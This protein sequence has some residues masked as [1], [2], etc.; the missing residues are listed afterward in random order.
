L[1]F[2]RA[3]LIVAIAL[4]VVIL[5]NVGIYYGYAR[6]NSRN[7]FKDMINVVKLARNPWEE[8]DNN[9]KELSQRVEDLKKTQPGGPENPTTA[10]PHDPSDLSHTP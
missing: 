10:P 3:F 2:S 5:F 7:E 4:V 9:L 1:D 6:K 8:E